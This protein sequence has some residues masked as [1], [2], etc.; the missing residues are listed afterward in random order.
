MADSIHGIRL[1]LFLRNGTDNSLAMAFGIAEKN[2]Q[3][4]NNNGRT[5][6]KIDAAYIHNLAMFLLNCAEIFLNNYNKINKSIINQPKYGFTIYL[7]GL[8]RKIKSNKCSMFITPYLNV[9]YIPGI[10]SI[11]LHR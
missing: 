11:L 6:G 1:L 4:M 7:L 5:R 3:K 9:K 2:N 8:Y 10:S